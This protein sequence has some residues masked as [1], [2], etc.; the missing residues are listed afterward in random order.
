[1][2]TEKE[3]MAM[4]N[5]QIAKEVATHTDIV[6]SGVAFHQQFCDR[7]Q[8]RKCEAEFMMSF[9]KIFTHQ[10]E[11]EI[12]KSVGAPMANYRLN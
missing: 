9:I 5:E 7:P 1:V 6:E 8:N 10:L 11:K 2:F 12:N 4:V 3:F